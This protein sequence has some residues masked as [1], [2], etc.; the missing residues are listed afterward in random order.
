MTTAT[1]LTVGRRKL[2][3]SNLDKVLYPA[4]GFTKGQVIHYY[5]EVAD[6]IIPHLKGRPLTLKRYPNGVE[7]KFFYEKNCPSHRPDWLTVQNRPSD[8]RSGGI[9]YCVVDSRPALLWVANLA[10]LELHVLLSRGKNHSRPTHMVFDLDPGEGMNI[11]DCARVAFQFRNMLDHLGLQSLV[12][13]S[14]SKGLHLYVPLN[15]AVTFEQTRA[16]SRAMASLLEKQ[17]SKQVTTSMRKD[18]RGGKVFI[19]WSQNDE[20]KTTVCAY[21]LR[22]KSRPSVSTP[23]TW[24]ELDSAVKKKS[25]DRLFFSPADIIKRLDK[26][27]DHFAPVLKLKQSLPKL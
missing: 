12:K 4:T 20:H 11:L 10:A 5:L 24:D 22:A 7:G 23:I 2:N 3:V 17:H 15:T 1:T 25:P 13:T 6:A 19:D 21:S 9:D 18:Q 26:H 27:G 8:R 14:G 16:F